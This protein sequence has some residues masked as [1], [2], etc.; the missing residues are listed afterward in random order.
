VK[1]FASSSPAEKSPLSTDFA[2]LTWTSAFSRIHFIETMNPTA[3]TILTS[4]H[5]R[6][7]RCFS[8]EEVLALPHSTLYYFRLRFASGRNN[9]YLTGK[10]IANQRD[11]IAKSLQRGEAFIE[12]T[13]DISI[14]GSSLI[15]RDFIYSEIVKGHPVCLLRRGR[16]GARILFEPDKRPNIEL[17]PQGWAAIQNQG[18]TWQPSSGPTLEEAEAIAMKLLTDLPH[19]RDELLIEW[20]V[21]DDTIIYC[22]ARDEHLSGLGNDIPRYFHSSSSVLLYDGITT[23]NGKRVVDQLDIDYDKELPN[24][25]VQ[26]IFNGAFLSH[27]VTRSAQQ[28]KAV[29]IKTL[30][31]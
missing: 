10:E 6:L 15:K 26:H 2:K 13:Y 1:I 30:D 31:L 25:G 12:A 29:R 18:F 27:C 21:A 14:G 19:T 4:H 9:V 7:P 5:L 11:E 3:F 22:D 20:F 8:L 17:V 24:D 28:K 23:E 16:C